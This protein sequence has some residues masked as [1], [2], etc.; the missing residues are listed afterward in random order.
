MLRSNSSNFSTISEPSEN[1]SSHNEVVA[2][3][4]EVIA[5]KDE[6]IAALRT[7]LQLLSNDGSDS[8][9]S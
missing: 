1:Y 8:K 5:A 9:V 7:Q 2:A 4:K 3:L 6:T